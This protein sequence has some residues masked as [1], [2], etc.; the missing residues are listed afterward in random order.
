MEEQPGINRVLI[1]NN[2]IGLVPSNGQVL[3]GMHEGTQIEL[4]R[5]DFEKNDVTNDALIVSIEGYPRLRFQALGHAVLKY[6]NAISVRIRLNEDNHKDTIV[7]PVAN[8]PCLDPE[9]CL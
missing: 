3:E 8:I 4:T 2:I 1:P 7:F 5:G 6:G 9:S